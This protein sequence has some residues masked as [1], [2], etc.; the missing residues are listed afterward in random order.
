MAKHRHTMTGRDQEGAKPGTALVPLGP[1]APF[2]PADC[3]LQAYDWF[4]L[5]HKRLPRSR[6]WI[7]ASD[8][9]KAL[10]VELW[11]AA[12]DEVPAG[13]LPND[14][15]ALS[16]L[17]G[18]GRRDLGP[19]LAVKE[20]V[21]GAWTLCSD[22]RWHHRTLA[23]AVLTAWIERLQSQKR[24]GKG[25]ASRYGGA[26][27]A[28]D[29]DARISDAKQRL[30]LL[31]GG[32]AA[33]QGSASSLP[34]GDGAAPSRSNGA[35]AK[36]PPCDPT[37][38]DSDIDSDSDSDSRK[39]GEVGGGAGGGKRSPRARA[40]PAGDPRGSRL[41]TGWYATS[42]LRTYAEA[43]GFTAEGV[44]GIEEDFRLYWISKAGKDARKVDWNATFMTWVRTER[45]RRDRDQR[46]RAGRGPVHGT[47]ALGSF[48]AGLAAASAE[49]RGDKGGG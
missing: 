20:E 21:L 48:V 26:F 37:R 34:K 14:D 39:P 31:Q 10:S 28:A 45:K 33:P 40:A 7:G 23:E 36:A 27:D 2:V 13:T 47:E 8:T 19:W 30:T 46:T 49:R 12:M 17:C 22:G 4:P 43:Q 1:P 24:S 11:C 3:N 16:D 9:A 18:Y 41:P 6:F 5:Y 29:F 32:G 35:G 42:E 44:D 38:Q 25:N 15:K